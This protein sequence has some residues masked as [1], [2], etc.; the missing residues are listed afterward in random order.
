M[1]AV[2]VG[3]HLERRGLRPGAIGLTLTIGLLDGALSGLVAAAASA[4]VGRRTTLAVAGVLMALTGF[5]LAFAS[6]S[7]LLVLA[8]A[9]GMLGAASVDLGP[10]AAVEQSA[11]AESLEPGRRNL[12]CARYSLSGGLAVA[13]GG[14]AAGW[15]TDLARGQFVFAAYGGASWSG[16]IS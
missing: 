10:F 6:G 4:R 5:D 7:W 15:A 13:D 1:A 12:G 16:A 14:L 2:V 11:L 8:G 3:L 9:T